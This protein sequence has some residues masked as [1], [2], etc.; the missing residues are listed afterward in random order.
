MNPSP[1]PPH[2]THPFP[3]HP[4]A[5]SIVYFGLYY[6]PNSVSTVIIKGVSVTWD[7]TL[8]A[9]EEYMACGHNRYAA[10]NHKFLHR[11]PAS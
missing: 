7:V 6:S 5:V 11:A 10:I 1:P 3:L 9:P 2:P 4:P 8:S